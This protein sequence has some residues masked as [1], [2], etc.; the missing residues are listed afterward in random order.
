VRLYLSVLFIED[1]VGIAPKCFS[2]L[3]H[4]HDF[5]VHLVLTPSRIFSASFQA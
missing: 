5:G 4:C 3:N 2:L 1:T